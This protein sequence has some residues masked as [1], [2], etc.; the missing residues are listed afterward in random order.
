MK[1]GIYPYVMKKTQVTKIRLALNLTSELV[2]YDKLFNELASID[3]QHGEGSPFAAKMR[4]K[5]LIEI[6]HMYCN[7]GFSLEP[8]TGKRAP[9]LGNQSDA[10]ALQIAEA[11][12]EKP[13]VAA[14]NQTE[15]AKASLNPIAAEQSSPTQSAFT[16][17]A[18]ISEEAS[19]TPYCGLHK[20]D[21]SISFGKFV[22]QA[23]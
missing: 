12:S 10:L 7:N 1:F 17:T 2:G 9:V 13:F 18:Q 14:V 22:I 16:D 21:G 23:H 19:N 11:Q 5:H 4:R 3:A 20:P 8:G 6:L 15:T